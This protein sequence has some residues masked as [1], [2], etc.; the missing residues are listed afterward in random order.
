MKTTTN[1]NSHHK[2]TVYSTTI[3]NTITSKRILVV[4]AVKAIRIIMRGKESMNLCRWAIILMR[5]KLIKRESKKM[6]ISSSNKSKKDSIQ[7]PTQSMKTSNSSPFNM[8][9]SATDPIP[10]SPKINQFKKKRLVLKI[11][12]EYN[13]KTILIIRITFLPH[14][15]HQCVASYN[16]SSL[17]DLLKV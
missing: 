10:N 11:C 9:I 16:L 13:H 8:K 12:R 5:R 7:T 1:S 14:T 6:F 3:I 4:V 15:V 17:L 2:V